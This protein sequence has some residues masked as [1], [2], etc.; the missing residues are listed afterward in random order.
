[1]G[2]DGAER[3]WSG[4]LFQ[5]VGALAENT[6]SPKGSGG[7][8]GFGLREFSLIAADQKAPVVGPRWVLSWS[9]RTAVTNVGSAVQGFCVG[10]SG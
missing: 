10:R 3:L 1:M 5:S 2:R 6:P 4:K 7:T 9:C 8:Q